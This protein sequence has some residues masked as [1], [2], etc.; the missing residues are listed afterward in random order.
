MN[1]KKIGYSINPINKNYYF[2]TSTERALIER[3][4]IDHLLQ[5]HLQ[6]MWIPET[7]LLDVAESVVLIEGMSDVELIENM[8]VLEHNTFGGDWQ[9]DNPEEGSMILAVRPE[10]YDLFKAGRTKN[11]EDFFKEQNWNYEGQFVKKM[12]F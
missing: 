7:T 6:R 11:T 3:S 12:E 2:L 5:N 10:I 1:I 8:A 4:L 9:S